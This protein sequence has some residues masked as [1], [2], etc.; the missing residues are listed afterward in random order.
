MTFAKVFNF[1]QTLIH[2]TTLLEFPK[3]VVRPKDMSL[4]PEKFFK[5]TGKKSGPVKESLEKMK[6]EMEIN[7]D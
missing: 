4:S 1:D 6:K 7:H 5:I 2:P 3:K